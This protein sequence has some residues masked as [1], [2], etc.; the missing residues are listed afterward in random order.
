MGSY[1]YDR[2]V[3]SGSS[4]SS[5]GTSDYSA[6][7][8]NSNKLDSSMDP[9]GKV[10]KST[11]KNPIVIALDVTGS[12]IDFARLVY[13]KM[14]MF[15]GEI[16][17][18]G[19][20]DDFDISVCAVGDAYCDSYPL[21]I[22]S[23][24]KGIELDSWL[25]KLVLEGG[26]GGQL[27]E[28]YELAAHYLNRAT[29]FDKDAKPMVFF[30]ADEKPYDKVNTDQAKSIGLPCEE[31]YDPFPE[32]NKKFGNRVYVMLNKYCSRTFKDEIT[33]EWKKRLPNQHVIRIPEEKAIVDLI[34][35]I[36]AIESQ[37][38]MDEYA[39][40]MKDRGQTNAR[41]TGVTSSLKELSDSLEL[42]RVEDLNTD[43]PMILNMKK[44]KSGNRI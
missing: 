40:D 29:S 16:E 32:L 9:K 10:L 26:G 43:L 17:K 31:R 7:K 1:S 14:P 15:Y 6:S 3:Y 35:G 20:L 30:I 2:D 19:Y 33:D 34:L 25:E 13:D 4:Y 39:I 12:N 28:S 8:L 27:T 23:F 37:K 22:G 18:K 36:L 24:A 5:W 38:T 41:I 44:G 11:S 21:Q 42:A